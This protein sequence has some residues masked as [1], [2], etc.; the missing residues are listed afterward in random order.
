MDTCAKCGKALENKEAGFF[1]R[2][3]KGRTLSPT[4]AGWFP[5]FRDKKVCLD[6]EAEL[7]RLAKNKETDANKKN[8]Q[9]FKEAREQPRENAICRNCA[10]LEETRHD[11]LVT[12]AIGTLDKSYSTFKCK[13]FNQ[14]LTNSTSAIGQNCTSFITV[15]D[16]KQ[17]VLKEEAE[18]A[19]S[20]VQ[21]ILDFSSLKDVMA[22]GGLVMSTYKCP[23]C[24][25]MVKLPK[26]GNMLVCE[27]CGAS[28]KP[29]DVFEK[30]KSLIS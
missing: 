23:N 16:Y 11:L 20:N 28:I 22:K 19:K 30:I 21:I 8:K 12:D 5:E 7:K 2:R 9:G 29:V 1:N 27:Y 6:C 14:D 10:H 17:Q 4:L 26:E 24:N 15:N 18:K 3:S 25:G 13:K